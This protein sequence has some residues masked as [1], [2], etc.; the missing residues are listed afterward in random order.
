MLDKVLIINTGGTIG[1]VHDN[2]NDCNS[3]LRPA[4][5]W[6]E[7]IKDHPILNNFPTDY[8]QFNP[9]IDSSDM[10]LEVWIKIAEIIELDHDQVR[11]AVSIFDRVESE[12]ETFFRYKRFT[13]RCEGGTLY[14]VLVCFP[15]YY[16]ILASLE[17]SPRDPTATLPRRPPQGSHGTPQ[18]SGE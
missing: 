14:I 15:H 1:M 9:L 16:S 18:G 2:E 17:S 8:H 7:I 10:C 13:V 12:L 4:I 3:P 5:N 6:T 11:I